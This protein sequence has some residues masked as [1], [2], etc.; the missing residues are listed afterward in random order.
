[1]RGILFEEVDILTNAKLA[2]GASTLAAM[3][4]WQATHYLVTD[5]NGAPH[6]D[7]IGTEEVVPLNGTVYSSRAESTFSRSRVDSLDYR[8][9]IGPTQTQQRDT[10]HT[11]KGD[12]CDKHRRTADRVLAM[13][14]TKLPCKI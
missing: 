8:T 12:S 3:A 10:H 4:K 5:G 1:M 13:A 2:K 11:D 7:P 6:D 14:P 9:S